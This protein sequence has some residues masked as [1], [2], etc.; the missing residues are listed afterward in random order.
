M[1][2]HIGAING[3]VVPVIY[4]IPRLINIANCI[5]ATSITGSDILFNT[6]SMIMKMA[7]I[8]IMFTT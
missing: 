4:G 6:M 5:T 2:I 3:S 7:A 8:D 1:L